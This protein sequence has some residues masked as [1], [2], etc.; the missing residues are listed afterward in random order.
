MHLD[1]GTVA[2]PALFGVEG[3]GYYLS[4]FEKMRW[5]FDYAYTIISRQEASG[6]FATPNGN[7]GDNW[8]GTDEARV[9]EQSYH[10]LVLEHSV[11]GGCVDTDGDGVCDSVDNCPLVYNPDQKD[12]DGDGIGDACDKCPTQPGPLS[13]GGC[14]LNPPVKLNVE[15]R[16]V[17]ARRELRLSTLPVPVSDRPW[18][19]APGDVT[20]NLSLSC[21]GSVAA[22]TTG[23]MVKVI[24]GSS[25]RIHFQFTGVAIDE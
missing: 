18:R 24:L 23:T 4:L 10:I 3:G 6:H 15:P 14:P 22:S 16:R 8:T 19:D 17:L 20:I 5:Y 2:R 9:A 25:S 7:W 11:G 21:N 1:P 12:T 13:N